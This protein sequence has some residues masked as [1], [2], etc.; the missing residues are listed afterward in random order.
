MKPGRRTPLQATRWSWPDI[1]MCMRILGPHLEGAS[2]LNVQTTD[3]PVPS[4]ELNERE[5]THQ[6]PHHSDDRTTHNRCRCSPTHRG[7]EP[8]FRAGATDT[9]PHHNKRNRKRGAGRFTGRHMISAKQKETRRTVTRTNRSQPPTPKS[10]TCC[11]CSLRCKHSS[12]NCCCFFPESFSQF[13]RAVA[14]LSS[15]TERHRGTHG[16]GERKSADPLPSAH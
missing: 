6:Y 5:Q 2:T 7:R 16:E 8:P 11:L 13:F 15:D 12:E 10:T 1:D 3:T 9:V 14:E 4:A